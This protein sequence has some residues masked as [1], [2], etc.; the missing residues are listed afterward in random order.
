LVGDSVLR[1]FTSSP[2]DYGATLHIGGG[3][4]SEAIDPSR[5]GM[6][7]ISGMSRRAQF[8]ADGSV[9]LSSQFG[10]WKLGEFYGERAPRRYVRNA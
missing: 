3:S 4:C 10:G 9:L 8:L 6:G 2:A 7:C 5:E 1:A